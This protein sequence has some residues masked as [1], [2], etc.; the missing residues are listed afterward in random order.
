MQVLSVLAAPATF[1]D[2]QL[3]CLLAYRMVNVS[4]QHGMSGASAYAYA[5]ACLGFIVGAAFHRYREG[6][7]L[8][9]LACDLVEK[10]SSTAYHTKVDRKTVGFKDIRGARRQCISSLP[11]FLSATS[12]RRSEGIIQPSKV[13]RQ[14]LAE[15]TGPAALLLPALRRHAGDRL[16][17]SDPERQRRPR[18]LRR[19]RRA[20]GRRA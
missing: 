12:R 4:I 16:G 6:Y 14:L 7:R 11:V 5:Y 17:Y 15:G 2:F 1:A 8:G 10:H 19:A 18:G 3:F 20:A 13:S 9:R